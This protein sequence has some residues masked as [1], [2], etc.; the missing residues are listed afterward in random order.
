MEKNSCNLKLRATLIAGVVITQILNGALGFANMPAQLDDPTESQP[1]ISVSVN[2]NSSPRSNSTFSGSL[3]PPSPL[4]PATG[5]GVEG[6]S[7]PAQPAG[8]VPTGTG[9]SPV[10]VSPR[11]VASPSGNPSTGPANE[12]SAVTPASTVPSGATALN[13]VAGHPP[14]LSVS[15]TMTLTV[16]ENWAI[17]ADTIRPVN[18]IYYFGAEPE[19]YAWQGFICCDF[20]QMAQALLYL[21]N[22]MVSGHV[23]VSWVDAS[24]TAG[25]HEL[26]VVKLGEGT[27][28]LV[29]VTGSGNP[30]TPTLLG[31]WTVS[32]NSDSVT[33]ADLLAQYN[34]GL[35]GVVN[36]WLLNT[37]GNCHDII[38]TPGFDTTNGGAPGGG[39]IR[40]LWQNSSDMYNNIFIHYGIDPNIIYTIMGN[41]IPNWVV[42]DNYLN[43]YLG[44]SSPYADSYPHGLLPPSGSPR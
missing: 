13:P 27:F 33:L 40:P 2:N 9:S 4:S 7:A 10:N 14:L 6:P 44:N 24:G 35:N 31:T 8:S 17:I 23:T 5:N 18:G 30:V 36:A 25:A 21:L 29:D 34:A 15:A 42:D 38:I 16:D 39:R 43:W 26:L 3:M 19:N 22:N 20:V 1:G 32:A 41:G 28:G 12:P 11:T 37:Y